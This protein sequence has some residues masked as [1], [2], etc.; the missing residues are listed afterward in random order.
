MNELNEVN[1]HSHV[2]HRRQQAQTHRGG[3]IVPEAHGGHHGKRPIGSLE[4]RNAAHGRV[5][6]PATRERGVMVE[7]EGDLG[8]EE[9]LNGGRDKKPQGSIRDIFQSKSHAHF[10]LSYLKTTTLIDLQQSSYRSAKCGTSPRP[11][12]MKEVHAM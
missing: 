12:Q 6:K 3:R 1:G 11:S 7:K 4:E 9:R 2:A 10:H 5:H 8:N